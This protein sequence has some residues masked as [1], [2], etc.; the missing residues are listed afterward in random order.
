LQ[1]AST[2]ITKKMMLPILYNLT[3]KANAAQICL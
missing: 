1:A 3:L 2:S